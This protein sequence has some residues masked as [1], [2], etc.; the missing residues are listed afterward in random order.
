MPLAPRIAAAVAALALFGCGSSESQ[1]VRTVEVRVGGATVQAEVAASDDA[2]KQGLSGR[3]S[4]AEDRGMLFVYPGHAERTYWMKGM[5]FPIDI[6]WIDSGRV[7]RVEREVPVP[8]GG[9]LPLYSSRGPVDRV[10]EVRSG[11]AA[12]HAAGPGDRVSVGS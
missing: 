8:A 5:R 6:V 1:P 9:N 2:R 10:L 11:W 7:T 3:P 4:L 12:R